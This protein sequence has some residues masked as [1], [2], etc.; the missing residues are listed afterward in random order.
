[1]TRWTASQ[2]RR[3]ARRA[4]HLCEYCHTQQSLTG[5]DF[6]LDHIH[7]ASLGGTGALDNLCFCC[8]WCN[9]F[10]HAQITATDPRTKVVV[11]LFH[12]RRDRWEEHF[13]WDATGTHLRGRTAIG[14]ATVAALRLNRASLVQARRLWVQ[15]KLHPPGK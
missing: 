15:Y 12:P 10:K 3:V 7:P 13:H 5:H 9:N 14:R 11:S 4:N 8:F 6:T 2:R 1:M